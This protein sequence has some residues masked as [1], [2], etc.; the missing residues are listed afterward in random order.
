MLTYCILRKK[1]NKDDLK[2]L[3]TGFSLSAFIFGPIWGVFKR[4]WLFSLIGFSLFFFSKLIYKE[5]NLFY[6][7]YLF[8]SISSFFWGFFA[9]DLLILKLIENNFYPVKHINAT[10]KESAIIQFLSEERNE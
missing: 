2:I 9:R 10:S 7:F 5:T 3:E 8:S 6:I 4:L 1:D